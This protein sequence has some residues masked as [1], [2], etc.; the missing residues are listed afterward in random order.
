M[1]CLISW[2]HRFRVWKNGVYT[3]SDKQPK[4][5]KCTKSELHHLW[6]SCRNPF[7]MYKTPL[8]T[9]YCYLPVSFPHLFLDILL[10]LVRFY[11]W[12]HQVNATW[13]LNSKQNFSFV[14]YNFWYSFHA[15]FFFVSCLLIIIIIIIIITLFKCQC[16]LAL[17]C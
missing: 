6:P 8:L 17:L 5:W 1:C 10:L 9:F 11:L 12:A 16:I 13:T 2:F 15:C 4:S 7:T 14:I 3:T